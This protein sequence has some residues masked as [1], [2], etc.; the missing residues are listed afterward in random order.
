MT[1]NPI[2][3][4]EGSSP[5]RRQPHAPRS[6]H[7]VRALP[8]VGPEDRDAVGPIP[9]VMLRGAWLRALGFDVGVQVRIEAIPGQLTVT[10][11]WQTPPPDAAAP[12]PAKPT[13]RYAEVGDR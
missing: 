1:T 8:Q 3:P 10:S 5:S 9:F 6:I 7:N 4:P 11:L 12:A 2:K 13:L